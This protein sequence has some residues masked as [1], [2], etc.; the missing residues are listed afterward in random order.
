MD[1]LERLA[2]AQK[3]PR[4]Y[5]GPLSSLIEDNLANTGI[6][7]HRDSSA[8]ER[9]N[10]QVIRED[11]ESRFGADSVIIDRSSHWA[12]GW[13][14]TILV[15]AWNEENVK[16]GNHPMIHPAFIAA[17]DWLDKLDNYPVADDSHYSDLE[18]HEFCEYVGSEA[19]W[20]FNRVMDSDNLDMPYPESFS[21][22]LIETLSE[23]HFS[24]DDLSDS[25]VESASRYCVEQEFEAYAASLSA[26]HPDQI[27]LGV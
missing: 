17:C 20:Y 25:A 3:A 8:L 16:L 2:Q 27:T 5:F 9:S 26:P 11:L 18:Y 22:A 4:D 13:H 12:V 15:P 24:A 6:G 23:D 1:I 10:F 14:E 7:Q 21:S 19:E